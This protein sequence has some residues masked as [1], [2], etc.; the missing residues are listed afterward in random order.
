MKRGK[1]T[2]N[3]LP[4]LKEIFFKMKTG[5]FDFDGRNEKKAMEEVRQDIVEL[6]KG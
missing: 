3:T 1:N 6:T 5:S 4:E 2:N